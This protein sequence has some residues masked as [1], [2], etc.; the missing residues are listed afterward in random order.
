[1]GGG[2]GGG[3]GGRGPGRGGGGGG[4]EKRIRRLEAKCHLGHPESQGSSVGPWPTGPAQTRCLCSNPRPSKPSGSA[5][6]QRRVCA[7]GALRHKF[8]GVPT[9]QENLVRSAECGR[10]LRVKGS[11]PLKQFPLWRDVGRFLKGKPHNPSID[12]LGGVNQV[13]GAFAFAFGLSGW[14]PTPAAART[15]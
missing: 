4:E 2:G 13:W 8:L 11:G 12:G 14:T 9:I 10:S 15:T 5:R 7:A 6:V 1:M 3:G